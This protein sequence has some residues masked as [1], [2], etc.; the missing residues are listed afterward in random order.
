MKYF[1]LLALFAAAFAAPY[2]DED[3]KIVGGYEC[4]KNSVPYQVSL[5]GGYHFCGGS[6]ISSTWV[7]SAAHCYKSRIQV[8]LG[9][10]N[11]AVNEGTEQFISSAKVI[12]H[13]NYS[14]YSLDNDI[15]LIKLSKPATLNS[16]VK[17]VSLP[18]SC[19][20]AGS[21]CLISGWG[22]TSSSSSNYPDRLMCL[23]APILS[24][25]SCKN[26][27]PGQITANMFC[28]GFLEGGKDSCQGD[29]GG[30]VVCSGQLQGVV[31]WGYGCAQRNNPGV[32]TK[33]CNY[34][35]WIRNTMSS[36]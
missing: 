15:M 27:Y 29:S 35:T 18:S 8:R 24:D 34:N 10:H 33:V 19:A 2:G 12:R 7:V 14:S 1:I 22:N 4:R 16:Y 9:E 20:S 21:T 31:S 36:N 25:S 28:A 6:L 3:D 13:P 26:S 17:T 5:N 23:D 32:Y 30:P 11:I